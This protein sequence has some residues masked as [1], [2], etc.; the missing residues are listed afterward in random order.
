MK[1]I[2]MKIASTSLNR[3]EVV[4]TE[5]SQLGKKSMGKKIKINLLNG[6]IL[7]FSSFYLNFCIKFVR[8]WFHRSVKYEVKLPVLISMKHIL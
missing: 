5:A 7:H 2:S 3:L 1:Q 6:F 8:K 4:G